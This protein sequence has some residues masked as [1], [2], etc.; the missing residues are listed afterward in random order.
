[1]QVHKEDFPSFQTG[2]VALV[3]KRQ[4]GCE[5]QGR[6]ELAVWRRSKPSDVVTV[7]VQEDYTTLRVTSLMEHARLPV[8]FTGECSTRVV[9]LASTQYRIHLGR[10]V[11]SF[12]SFT[13]RIHFLNIGSF[14]LFV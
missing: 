5:I 2:E 9:S 8:K 4:P 7:R 12:T 1:M 3:V 13:K 14:S 6:G 11:G 10:F